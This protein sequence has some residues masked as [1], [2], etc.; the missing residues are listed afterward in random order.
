MEAIDGP[1][2]IIAGAGSGKTR[3]LTLRVANLLRHGARPGQVLALTFTN[4]AAREMKDRLAKL[5]GEASA[6]GLWMGTF[7]S[8]FARLLRVEH[9]RLGYPASFTIYDTADS[10]NLIK[11]IVRG[12]QL[13]DQQY[14]P[15]AVLSRISQAKNNLVM[16]SAYA[17]NTQITTADAAAQ[18]P[19]LYRVYAE[20]ERRCRQAGAMDFDDLL[21]QT[22]V[23]L[24]DHPE[25]L[26]KYRQKFRH[27]LVDEYQD[28]NHSQYRI[29]QQLAAEHRNLC[30][31]GD[32][33][34]SIYAF[35]GARIENIL[36]FQHDFADAKVFRLERNYRSTQQIVKAANSVIARNTRQLPKNVFSE[37]ELGEPVLVM[38]TMTDT[39][40]GFAVAKAIQDVRLAERDGFD[41]F[42]ILY[43]TNAQSR[44]FEES[45]RKLGI[46]HRI[47]G[48]MSF[49]QRKEVKDVLA[50][51]RL[52]V[53][54][55][56]DEALKRVINYPKRGIGDTTVKALVDA[57][58]QS[59]MPLWEVLLQLPHPQLR[60]AP[61][62]LGQIQRFV[63]LIQGFQR[64][65]ELL[66][67]YTLAHKAAADSGILK[68]LYQGTAPED[69]SRHENVQELLNAIRVFTQGK[70]ENDEPATLDVFLQD[71]ALLTD[72]DRDDDD[73]PRVTLMTIHSAKG[74]EFRNVFIVGLEDG[75]FPSLRA[76]GSA[77][78][79]EEE[80]RL[81][82]V[83][84]TR[85][86]KRLFLSLAK[87][88][89]QWG[90]MAFL[91][92]SRFLAE[93]DPQT[94]Q[95]QSQSGFSAPSR[96]GRGQQ[97]SFFQAPK[98]SPF[99]VRNQSVETSSQPTQSD[100]TSTV[101]LKPQNKKLLKLDEASQQAKEQLLRSSRANGNPQ[102]RVGVQVEHQKFGYGKITEMEEGPG[103]DISNAKITVEF[104]RF[105]RK[106]LLLKFANIKVIG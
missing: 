28:T 41:Q 12:M 30:V 102:L 67:A 20:Y 60:V 66:D 90:K 18:R 87:S 56:D 57:A 61:A 15:S 104:N 3:V 8:I 50:Y 42:A 96:F 59:Q 6:R 89:F 11:D 10:T 74:L 88:R 79:L 1:S 77:D 93:L 69:V 44:V 19:Y 85:A 105:G 9:E 45:L 52:V 2:L 55:F 14:K 31:V 37:N 13:N 95:H 34:Q 58:A 32:D 76:T 99:Q 33:A 100:M 48:G 17:H 38:E 81:F 46:P 63:Q 43:R 47:Y 22:N 7:H 83:A 75:L 97:A 71:V 73:Q 64:E 78:E 51:L 27:I 80:R 25:V 70:H 103:G 54:P 4:K 68:E 65:M 39:E 24:R 72:Q 49:Y 94:L 84:L 29:I 5:V 101:D 23:L 91:E 36:N 21:L 53:N 62:T 98:K 82:Y 106:T 35:R 40:E 16:A 86:Q 92:P 26:D